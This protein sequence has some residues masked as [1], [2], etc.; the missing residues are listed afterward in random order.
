MA[1]PAF[2][3]A[4]PFTPLA[5]KPAFDPSKPFETAE[6]ETGPNLAEKI[7]TGARSAFEGATLG[8]SEP[9]VSGINAIVSNLIDAGFDAESIGEFTKQAV[10]AE[11]IKQ[12]YAKDIA[13]RK[14]L[15]AELPEIAIP[16]EIAGG[17]ATG[18][19]TGGAGA[20]PGALKALAAPTRAV[21][22]LAGAVAK[23]VPTTLGQAVAR[24]AVGAG[25][26]EALKGAVQVPTGVATPEEIDVLGAA[27]FGGALGGG[28]QAG[29]SGIKAAPVIGK[30]LLQAFGGVS[31]EGI[32]AY[33][34][35]PGAFVRAKSPEQIKASIDAFSEE[36]RSGVE[37]GNVSVAAADKAVSE[38]KQALNQEISKRSKEF[39]SAKFDA[40]GALRKAEEKLSEA[41]KVFKAD[42]EALLDANKMTL[43]D[44]TVEAVG[45][46]KEKVIRESKKSY[47][48]LES[49]GRVVS[50]QP[51]IDAAEEALEGLKVQGKAPTAGASAQ[52]F[53][54]IKS[55]VDDLKQYK[56]ILSTSDAKKKI[57]QLDQ[58]YQAAVT[59]GEFTS[60]AQRALRSIRRAFDEQLKDIPEY[61][62]V[63][64]GL[65]RDT[66]LL[67]RANLK[68]GNLDKAGA[69]IA[70][71]DL[72]GRDMDRA[73]VAELGD[74]TGRKLQ[75]RIATIQTTGQKLT[76]TALTAIEKASPEAAAFR[77]AQMAEAKLR[78]PGAEEA[79]MGGVET[80]SPQAIALRKA[81]EELQIRQEQLLKVK[82]KLKE[83]GPFGKPLSNISAI[84]NVLAERNPE[85]LK[86]L[87]KMSELADEDLVKAVDDLRVAQDFQKEF[88]I[89]SRNVNLWG[90]GAGAAAYGI[91]GDIGSSL[92]IA[93]MGGGFGS[94][95]D[96]F[97]PKMTKKVLD[98]YL[99]IEGLPT[100]Q[101]I[102]Q[103]YSN[104]PKPVVNQL[105]DDLIRTLAVST[106]EEVYLSPMQAES[107]KQDISR[108]SLSS[109]QKAKML[110][111][112]SK[113]KP[114]SSTD[115]SAVMIGKKA[116]PPLAVK[117]TKPPVLKEDKPDI[118]KAMEEKVSQ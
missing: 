7:E 117:L 14:Q 32:E 94:L 90:L 102:E 98:G 71:I 16:S 65:S 37:S 22:A 107:A 74:A 88:R 41:K 114:L 115:L 109:I 43:R 73:L 72:P 26:A 53:N 3:P 1:K 63:M 11:A 13:R 76:P 106:P 96:R 61:A 93:G 4:T 97:G 35:D 52:A 104:L 42:T 113:N 48:I 89:G 112:L 99:K 39:Q 25:A 100:V 54:Q 34:K 85:Y 5:D 8:L 12:E 116:A 24:G 91:T 77:R 33:L 40:K 15:E 56:N 21:E 60:D 83:I 68:L 44:E 80:A 27:K 23:K 38:A 30:R 57:Q 108:S 62:Q 10:N 6:A 31:E 75:D 17:V 55:Y 51:A 118:L 2:N 79:F 18:L 50:V 95:V 84:G 59:A 92:V 101:K 64:A 103:V 28:V 110:D 46:L 67:Q 69:K 87:K 82:N 81:Q 78:I 66:D 20:A 36:L 49:S 45:A 9:V 70:R 29:I 58:D 19:M 105:K 86:I 47:D 111:A